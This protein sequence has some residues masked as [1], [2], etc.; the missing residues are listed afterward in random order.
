M[1]LL[2]PETNKTVHQFSTGVETTGITCMAWACNRTRRNSESATSKNAL[3]SLEELLFDGNV[4]PKSKFALDLPR[5]LSQID[6]ERSLPK[7][8]VLA[9]GS[10]S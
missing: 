7:L 1:R 8:S 9:P 6:I 10:T 4:L 3:E 5:D 2:G